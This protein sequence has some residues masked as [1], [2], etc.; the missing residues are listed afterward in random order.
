VGAVV[1]RLEKGCRVG[2]GCGEWRYWLVR[3]YS[4][5]S[6]YRNYTIVYISVFYVAK[7]ELTFSYPLKPL[8]SS[9]WAMTSLVKEHDI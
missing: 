9:S 4:I 1:W 2:A 7:E 3:A 6:S 5:S 8:N